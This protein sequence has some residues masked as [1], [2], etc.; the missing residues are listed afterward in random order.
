MHL[1]WWG[2]TLKRK[3]S[4]LLKRFCTIATVEKGTWTWWKTSENDKPE[5]KLDK[6]KKQTKTRMNINFMKKRK[7]PV[8]VRPFSGLALTAWEK[9]P[10]W[11]GRGKNIWSSRLTRI[12]HDWILIFL[13]GIFFFAI[14]LTL[15]RS[16]DQQDRLYL[17]YLLPSHLVQKSRSAGPIIFFFNF[18]FFVQKSRK[19][20]IIIFL[21]FTS[22]FIF[23]HEISPT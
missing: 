23:F 10:T 9:G 8:L 7:K 19:A 5:L 2:L 18:S 6:K 1:L 16:H 22:I 13:K 4:K 12:Y 21:I 11:N 17:K 14:S 3:C 15:S 20:R